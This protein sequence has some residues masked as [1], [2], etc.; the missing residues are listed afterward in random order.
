VSTVW[1]KFI[2]NCQNSYN[3]G[4]TITINEQL[5]PTKAS[6]RFTQYLPNKPDKFG[7][8][9]WLACDVETKYIA[10]GFPYLGKDE[11]RAKSQ[12]LSEYVVLKLIEPFTMKG[13]N[14]TTENIFTCVLLSSKLL[15]KKT[16]LFGTIHGRKENC[17][18]FVK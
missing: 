7:I 12:P 8:E 10:N 17:Q 9:F 3:P 5:L 4:Q 16:T 13:R 6:C 2:E 1:E 15:A 11:T 18:I 14:V